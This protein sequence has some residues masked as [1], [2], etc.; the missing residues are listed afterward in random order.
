MVARVGALIAEITAATTMGAVFSRPSDA[1]VS[2][3]AEEL[4]QR[5][6]RP[7]AITVAI[8]LTGLIFAFG[9][10]GKRP[11]KVMSVAFGGVP[12]WRLHGRRGTA[13]RLRNCSKRRS[14]WPDSN[15]RPADYESAA[16]PTELHRREEGAGADSCASPTES[17]GRPGPCQAESQDSLTDLS[18]PFRML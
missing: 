10:G 2:P 18:P 3:L 4:T 11:G 7:V 9:E 6:S 1:A 12:T 17:T 8:V 13:S 5:R 14:R 15:R 16:L